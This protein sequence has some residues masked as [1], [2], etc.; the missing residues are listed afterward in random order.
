MKKLRRRPSST[1]IVAVIA[2]VVAL[3]G[4]AVAAKK[5]GLNALSP[6]AKKKTVGVGK[7][8][9]VTAEQVYTGNNPAEGY[10]LT[11]T[12]PG[13]THVLGGGTKVASGYPPNF[14][15]SLIED[16]PNTS[17][18]TARFYAGDTGV[19]DRV[20]VTASC[21]VSQAVTGSPPAP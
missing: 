19:T 7:L 17:G 6:S 14:T 10:V 18:F 9:Y 8:T 2:L 21:G 13:G 15:F 20:A 3:G 16:Y 12:C 4:T 11:A 1:M 5:L